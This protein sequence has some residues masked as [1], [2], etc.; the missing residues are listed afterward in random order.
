MICDGYAR[1]GSLR[2]VD[3]YINSAKSI[4]G[5]LH[6]ILYDRFIVRTGADIRLHRK[7]FDPI[8]FLQFFLR[9]GQLLNITSGQHQIGTFFGIGRCDTITDGTALS[10]T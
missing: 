7:Y 10:I 5:L 9:V 1:S 4:N 2:I 8:L 3:Q 6:H